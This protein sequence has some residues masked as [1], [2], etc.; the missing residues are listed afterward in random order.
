MEG[1]LVIA[2]LAQRWRMRMISDQEPE[3]QPLITL[4]PK[5]GIQMRLEARS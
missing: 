3:L 2:T 4:R 1:V 5:N